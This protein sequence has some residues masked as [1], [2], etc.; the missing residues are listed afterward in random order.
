M[1]PAP[2]WDP[3]QRP[4]APSVVSVT[5]DKGDNEMILGAVHRYPGIYITAEENPGRGCATSHCLKWVPFL[6]MRSVGSHSMSGREKEGKVSYV[7]IYTDA[8]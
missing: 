4:F 6:Q 3:S 5:N 8:L 2:V 1:P 7:N